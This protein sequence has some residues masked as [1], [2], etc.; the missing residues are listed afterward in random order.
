MRKFSHLLLRLWSHETFIE[1]EEGAN[2][3]PNQFNLRSSSSERVQ[4]NWS[5][6]GY[7]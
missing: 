7:R 6:L 4:P 3:N 1:S 2:W 5:D